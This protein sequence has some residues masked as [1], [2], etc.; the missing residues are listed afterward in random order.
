MAEKR[1]TDAWPDKLSSPARRALANAG[2]TR[3]EELTRVREQDLAKL[4]GMGPKALAQLKA[5]L[6][7]RGLG[8]K[9]DP[10]KSGEPA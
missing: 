2:F 7:E 3:L 1:N 10:S 6:T 8:F 9:R 4:H 5:A